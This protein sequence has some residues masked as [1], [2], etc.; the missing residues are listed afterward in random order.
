MKVNWMASESTA[1]V[2]RVEWSTASL[3]VPKRSAPSVERA[4]QGTRH[5]RV[6]WQGCSFC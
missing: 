5:Q 1:L 4:A 6:G 2:H 3:W